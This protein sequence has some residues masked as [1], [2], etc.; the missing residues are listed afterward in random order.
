MSGVYDF[1][2][3]PKGFQ[4][5]KAYRG[6]CRQE[7]DER[8]DLGSFLTLRLNGALVSAHRTEPTWGHD[9]CSGGVL[10]H[11]NLRADPGQVPRHLS[12]LSLTYLPK[13][14]NT[15]LRTLFCPIS[16]FLPASQVP[17]PSGAWR[18][19]SSGK[20][21]HCEWVLQA[22]VCQPLTRRRTSSFW[23]AGRSTE[24]GKGTPD[25]G[26]WPIS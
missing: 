10:W 11:R 15:D 3:K 8:P 14:D 2:T 13:K 17:P 7:G 6:L 20:R 21:C 18:T 9:W 26:A 24:E 12:T 22:T 16:N 5:R 25:K 19:K 23:G 4:H 1:Q